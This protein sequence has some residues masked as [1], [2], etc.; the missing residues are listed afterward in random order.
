MLF[1][2]ALHALIHSLRSVP[3]RIIPASSIRII[4]SRRYRRRLLRCHR[5]EEEDEEQEQHEVQQELA[6]EEHDYG[7]K[8]TK[9]DLERSGKGGAVAANF[10]HFMEIHKQHLDKMFLGLSTEKKQLVTDKF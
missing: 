8:S 3:R 6:E 4:A 5:P 10:I 1:P 9:Y 2:R 7:G